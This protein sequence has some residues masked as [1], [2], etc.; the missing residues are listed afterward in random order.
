MQHDVEQSVPGTGV[1]GSDLRSQLWY[2][3]F[4]LLLSVMYPLSGMLGSRQ[5]IAK[6]FWARGAGGFSPPTHGPTAAPN[7][8]PYIIIDCH[9]W[10]WGRQGLEEAAFLIQIAF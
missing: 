9:I 6:E 1:P 3:S 8:P 5:E 4:S 7:V 10:L 2:Q